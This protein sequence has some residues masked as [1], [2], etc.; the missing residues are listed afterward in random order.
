MECVQI[1]MECNRM[2]MECNKVLYGV[3]KY[4]MECHD[5]E[6]P[7]QLIGLRNIREHASSPP[8]SQLEPPRIFSYV[9][10]CFGDWVGTVG[11]C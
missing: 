6:R 8:F 5:H 1:S 7:T 4:P 11:S 2:S 3:L 9:F 10:F